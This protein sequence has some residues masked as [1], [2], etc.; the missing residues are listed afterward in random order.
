MNLLK[1][2]SL[3][4]A[5]LLLAQLAGAAVSI[6]FNSAVVNPVPPASA[7]NFAPQL[8][9][10]ISDPRV[11][12]S[13]VLGVSSYGAAGKSVGLGGFYEDPTGASVR[14]S[15]AVSESLASKTFSVDLALIN[16]FAA[17][18]GSFL[19][20]DDRFAIVLSDGTDL[21]RVSFSPT[22]DEN[23]RRVAVNGTPLTPFGI[24]ASDYN[25][26]QWY[27][28]GISF[29]PRGLDLDYSLTMAGGSITNSGT[30]PNKSGATLSGLAVDFDRLGATAG[31]NFLLVDNFSVVP[32]P[33][34]GI[35]GLM[36]LG[37][38]GLRRRR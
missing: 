14:L 38:I 7:A 26:P 1:L 19:N 4:S 8:A 37:L 21:L 22:P 6:N 13:F 5:P 23:S 29:T 24:V 9:W 16:R 15:T 11:D 27:T 18:P 3:I 36:A 17:N 32:E 28:L 10:T 2:F 31:S 35:T 30:L 33:T 34:V 20:E 12:L 25:N